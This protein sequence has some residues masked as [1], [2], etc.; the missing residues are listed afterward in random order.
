MLELP[1][2][3]PELFQS[4]LA[5]LA[6]SGTIVVDQRPYFNPDHAIAP[7]PRS[8]IPSSVDSP[9]DILITTD[10]LHRRA[11]AAAETNDEL[12]SV[13]NAITSTATILPPTSTGTATSS[14]T[15]TLAGSSTSS[16]LSVAATA[17]AASLPTPFDSGFSSNITSTCSSFMMGFLANETFKS[18]LPFSLLLQNSMSFFQVT[19]SVVRITQTLD[20]SC[21]ANL[22]TCT[23]LM[24]SLAANITATNT[25]ASDLS[26]ANPLITQARLGLLA[27]KTLYTASCLKDPETSAYCYAEA[28]TNST[29]PSDAYI[30]FLPL[31][32]SLPGGSQPT[33]NTCLKNTMQVYE[34][35]SADRTSAIAGTYVDAATQVNVQCGPGFVNQSL[36]AA[37]VTGA[38]GRG[39]VVGLGGQGVL[40]MVLWTMVMGW[41][42]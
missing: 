27:Y 5:R 33:C 14:G 10:N 40:L 4:T 28:I 30:Y 8:K 24:S 12:S 25:C 34:A 23:N 41:L 21:S 35:A 36:A 9:S 31:N 11:D 39:V 32:T 18:C 37:A 3:V 16:G 13:S 15:S 26:A 22:N 2:E 6:R 42:V 1:K 29:S 19:K 7:A 38:A 20:A 17:T